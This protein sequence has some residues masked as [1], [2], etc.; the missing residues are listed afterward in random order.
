MTINYIQKQF[1][2]AGLEPGNGNNFFQ[3]VPMVSILATA[4]PN[5]KVQSPKGN[6]TLNAYDN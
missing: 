4:A 3:E 5:M 6:F 2:A 1:S